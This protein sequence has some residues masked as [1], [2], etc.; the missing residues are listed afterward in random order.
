MSGPF[1]R[2][3]VAAFGGDSAQHSVGASA[4]TECHANGINIKYSGNEQ[5]RNYRSL[6]T[7]TCST[8]VG[9]ISYRENSNFA[10]VRAFRPRSGQKF[11]RVSAQYGASPS[12]SFC[13]LFLAQQKKQARGAT[14]TA[15]LL[16]TAPPAPTGMSL[17]LPIPFPVSTNAN[18]PPAQLRGRG[19]VSFRI[20]Q[21]A[22][23]RHRN[24]TICALVHALSGPNRPFPMPSVTSL[25]TVHFTAPA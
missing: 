16:K 1:P 3:A 4:P 22:Y 10:P 2:P 24:V 7:S 9:S 15:S 18:P 13:L 20:I 6:P 21:S 12:A 14:V 23:S 8:F 17:I 19:I 25:S 5:N 11:A